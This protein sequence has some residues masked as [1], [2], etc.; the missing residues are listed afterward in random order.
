VSSP[1]VEGPPAAL[2]H[3]KNDLAGLWARMRFR[4]ATPYWRPLAPLWLRAYNPADP[5]G[6]QRNGP[7]FEHPHWWNSGA[8]TLATDWM[9]NGE[10]V[11]HV[12]L[13]AGPRTQAA[14]A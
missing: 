5:P 1:S 3:P 10:C 4:R 11:Q 13:P 14:S 8:S 6:G 2:R 7:S 9:E 12:F